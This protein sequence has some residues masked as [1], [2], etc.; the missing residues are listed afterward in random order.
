MKKKIQKS[1]K[2]RKVTTMTRRVKSIHKEGEIQYGEA[3]LSRRGR[4]K[5]ENG[6]WSGTVEK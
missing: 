3:T 2:V 1:R 6:T 4:I 5:E